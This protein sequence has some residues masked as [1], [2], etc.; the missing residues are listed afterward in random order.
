MQS[1]V[2]LYMFEQLG[3][4]FVQVGNIKDVIAG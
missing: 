2:K 3:L 4:V 1:A